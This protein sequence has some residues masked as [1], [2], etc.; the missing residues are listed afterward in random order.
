MTDDNPNTN[1]DGV[2]VP[3]L[4]LELAAGRP[5][6][7]VWVNQ[8]GG[9][10]YAIDGGAEYVKYGPPHD[11]FDPDPEFAR[12][13]WVS[14]FVN[15]P[16]PIDHGLDAAG[17]RWLRTVGIPAT[18]A[19]LAG[20]REHPD[21]VVPELGKA[22]RRFHD[23]VPVAGCRW[24]YSVDGRLAASS[25]VPPP[26]AER[27]ALDAV[28]CHGDAC[29]PNFLLDEAGRCVGYVDLGMLGVGDRWADLAPALLSL[30]WNFGEGWQPTFLEAY[31]IAPDPAKQEFYTWVWNSI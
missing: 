23:V 22:L 7:P 1:F 21:V 13:R 18:S 14:G 28:V 15:A 10:T 4:V 24:E 20:W 19:V 2:V 31:G 16:R 27:P 17:N 8:I 11:E 5:V 25:A 3:P 12:L 26:E 29:N 9:V 6:D 30:G